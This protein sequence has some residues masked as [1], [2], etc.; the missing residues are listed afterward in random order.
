MAAASSSLA[1]GGP[2]WRGLENALQDLTQRVHSLHAQWHQDPPS[3]SEEDFRSC[4]EELGGGGRGGGG[5]D[6]PELEVRRKPSIF[7]SR[8]PADL[9]M[10]DSIYQPNLY[11]WQASSDDVGV[12]DD[13]SGWQLAVQSRL[14][15]R[16]RA[17]EEA[18]LE[19]ARHLHRQEME[20]ADLF[21]E[22]FARSAGGLSSS[23]SLSSSLPAARPPPSTSFAE[24]LARSACPG[25]SAGPLPPSASVPRATQ[26]RPAVAPG[27]STAPPSLGAW[28]ELKP[29]SIGRWRQSPSSSTAAAGANAQAA[30]SETPRQV[31]TSR[32]ASQC[33][34]HALH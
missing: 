6:F 17:L 5:F 22:S 32:G 7:A 21:L 10:L 31:A 14:R 8:A 1:T 15:A 25:G 20:D 34:V 3:P 18:D 27:Q 19:A 11:A 33:C 12:E 23:F 26:N 13:V 2:D 24:G 9:A 28:P 30:V 29:S 16:Q 4:Q